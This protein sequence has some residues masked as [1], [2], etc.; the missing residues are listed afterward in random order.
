MARKSRK[1][2]EAQG[3]T[4]PAKP[5]GLQEYDA[6]KLRT[7]AYVRLSS[8]NNGYCTDDS[9]AT[10]IQLVEDYIAS[11]KELVLTE[12][13]VDNGVSGMRFD[14]PGFVQMMDGVKSGKVQCIVVKDLSRFGRDYLETGYYI[15][16]VFPLLNVRFIAINDNFDSARKSD[17]ESLSV[18][19]KNMVNAMYAKDF[20]KKQG[21][22]KEMCRKTGRMSTG[23][24]PFGYKVQDGNLVI[25]KDAEPYVRMMFAWILAGVTCREIAARFRLMDVPMP[26]VFT[27]GKQA[28]EGAEWNT[29]CVNRILHNPAYAGYVVMGKSRVSAYRG[30]VLHRTPRE[31]WVLFPDRHEPYITEEEYQV[32]EARLRE[33]QDARRIFADGKARLDQ[34]MPDCFPHMVYCAVCGEPM[35]Y[36]RQFQGQRRP[37]TC[38]TRYV[39]INK[40]CKG[41]N[42]QFREGGAKNL[43]VSQDYL[44]ITVMDRI[45]ELALI[46][47]DTGKMIRK[48]QA[49][50]GGKTVKA[51]RI[52]IDSKQAEVRSIDSRFE[53][54]Y[55]DYTEGILDAEEYQFL[56]EKTI[57]ERREKAGEAEMLRQRLM[58]MEKAAED[59]RREAERIAGADG[60]YEFNQTLVNE[61]VESIHVGEGGAVEIRFKC[62]DVF[63]SALVE[64]YLNPTAGN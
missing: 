18:P 50:D 39:C 8:E 61:L 64:E 1:N 45:R 16:K 24:A 5:D 44:K 33:N 11:H 49:A 19:I 53:R 17:M 32:I 59:Y 57:L 25:D 31:E 29:N 7:A 42:E 10:Q 22:F 52:S 63:R 34:E 20:S 15:E 55:V 47:A 12:T 3:K 60:L 58:E 43:D 4:A 23:C 36:D 35:H 2:K 9:I 37:G 13:Y 51:L 48:Q 21:I 41:R 27:G 62:E 6:P 40:K 38:A 56:K 28:R 14:R 46:A 26:Y 54:L 30:E